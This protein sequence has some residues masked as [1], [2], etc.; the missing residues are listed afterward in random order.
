MNNKV[1]PVSENGKSIS[2]KRALELFEKPYDVNRVI[3]FDVFGVKN[4]NHHLSVFFEELTRKKI[5]NSFSRD[6]IIIQTVKYAEELDFVINKVFE[7]LFEWFGLYYP[8]ASLKIESV[9]KFAKVLKRGVDKKTVS[10]I[11]GISDYSM[12]GDFEEK[13]VRELESNVAMFNCLLN[14]RDNVKKYVEKLMKNIAPNTALV[15][16]PVL[17]AKLISHANGLENLAKKPSSTIQVMGA[18]KALFRHLT[19][20]AKSPK[21]G[22]LLQHPLMNKV[23][24]KNR[25]KMARSIANKTSIAVKMDFYGKKVIKHDLLKSLNLRAVSL[26]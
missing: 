11:L 20:G 26:K 23:A 25:G 10:S 3:D 17:G 24:F 2:V 16:T 4:V 19:T 1:S 5:K 15:A 8:E 6:Q 18:E 7:R 14:E 9:E 13:D 21:H 22:L 12:G